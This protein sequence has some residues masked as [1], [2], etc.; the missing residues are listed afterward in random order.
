MQEEYITLEE[1]ANLESEKYKTMAQKISRD[2]EKQ[3]N[4]IT[5]KAE[6]GGKDRVLIAV[7]SLSKQAQE[8]YKKVMEIRTLAGIATELEEKPKEI[9]GPWYINMDLD[10]YIENY[11]SYY[12]KAVELGNVIRAFLDYSEDNRS[13][14]AEAFAREYLGKGQRTLYRYTKAYL[15]ASAWAI[16]KS[17]EDGNKYD[18]YKILSL[19]RK[20]K[21][22]GMFPSFTEEIKQVIKNIWFNKEFAANQGTREML[23]DKLRKVASVNKWEK[24]PSY[25]SVA[26]YLSYLMEDEGMYN[27]WYLA[28]F[29]DRDY[30]NKRMVKATRDTTALKVMQIVMGDEHTF[31]CWVAYKHPNGKVAAIKPKLVAWVD[32]RS[33]TIFGDV[34]CKDPN[35]NILKQ[36]LLKLIYSD[37]GGVPEYLYIDNGKDYT[38]EMMTGR[39]RKD[40]SGMDEAEADGNERAFDDV[41]R[42]FYKSIGIKDDHRALPY[43]PWSKGQVERFFGTVC[44]QFTKWM[45]SYTGT[46]T[47]SRTSAKVNKDIPKMLKENRLLTMD[48]FY[49]LWNTWLHDVYMH[50]NHSQLKRL[51]EKYT[52]PY[53][54]F[55]KVDEEEKY[56]KAA[57]PKSYATMLMM[58]SES[59]RVYNIGICK[60]GYEYR[61]EELCAYIDRKVDIKYDPE[62]VTT[63][64]VFDKNGRRICEARSQELLLIAPKVSQKALEEHMKAQKRQ[65]KRDRELLEEA[66]RPFE[67]L[68][69]QYVGFSS[70]T[71]GIDLMAGKYEGKQGKV[72]TLPHDRTYT[73]NP[74]VRKQQ[75]PEEH[76]SE[77]MNLQAENALKKIRAMGE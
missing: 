2:I 30:K 26:R 49:A 20:P 11:S 36:S 27:A 62:D 17:S 60:F 41:T 57:P 68:N 55:Y 73:Q 59:V 51:G 71:G 19:C 76:E 58:K 67:E 15:E 77:Y 12:Y 21:E 40:R 1:A 29:G 70:V 25:P 7:S 75:E 33:R 65:L 13:Q 24:I 39:K 5:K 50:K 14:Y 47:G 64:Y 42:G 3:Y 72:I 43:E 32:T 66:N 74:D 54:L 46:L 9:T 61:A 6:N 48:E 23:Y 34:I 22:T 10:W 16:K 4:V 35:S 63:I 45:T 56:F 28:A 38:S 44:N 18:F 69:D 53:D 8:A 31:D 37:P 52:T